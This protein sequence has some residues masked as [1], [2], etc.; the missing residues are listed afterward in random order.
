MAK[1][2]QAQ[3]KQRTQAQKKQRK[4]D[5]RKQPIPST[6]KQKKVKNNPAREL[7]L[8]VL[9]HLAREAKHAVDL[10]TKMVG[11]KMH[12]R[13][14]GRALPEWFEHSERCLIE[15]FVYISEV[16]QKLQKLKGLSK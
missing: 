7:R 14:Y 5:Q 4:Q 1:K 8:Y 10:H 15:K 3:G 2:K 12:P 6:Q 11:H 9:G 13:D 16:V